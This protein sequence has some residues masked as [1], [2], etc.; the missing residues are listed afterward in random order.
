[1]SPTPG[2]PERRAVLG[3]HTDNVWSVAF[4]PDRRTLAVAS[5]DRRTV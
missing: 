1:M 5:D 3:N 2:A 4:S